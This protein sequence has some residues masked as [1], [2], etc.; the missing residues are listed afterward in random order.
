[1]L[2]ICVLLLASG[3]VAFAYLKDSA[4]KI[5]RSRPKAMPTVV[6]VIKVAPGNARAMISAMGSVTPSKEV[7]LKARVSG[8]VIEAST[9][10]HPWW[11]CEQG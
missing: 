1:M 2:G 10:F 7:V 6:D 5:K 11:T 4:P 3:V 9:Q 8:E